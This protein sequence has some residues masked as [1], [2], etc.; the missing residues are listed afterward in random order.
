MAVAIGSGLPVNE[1]V[2]SMV[3]DIGG[4]TSEAAVISFDGIVVLQSIRVADDEMNDAILNHIK[5][6]IG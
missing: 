6:L 1:P 3:V 4:G 2:G 5:K